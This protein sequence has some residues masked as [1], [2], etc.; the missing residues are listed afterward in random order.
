MI[1]DISKRPKLEIPECNE[2]MFL[3]NTIEY[4]V[5]TQV[6]MTWQTMEYTARWKLQDI[7][8]VRETCNNEMRT[9]MIGTPQPV[10]KS[11]RKTNYLADDGCSWN[12]LRYE[13]KPSANTD[14]KDRWTSVQFRCYHDGQWNESN[15]SFKVHGKGNGEVESRYDAKVIASTNDDCP[16]PVSENKVTTTLACRVLRDISEYC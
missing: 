8:A 9:Y 13:C 10:T 6:Q 11:D 7:C 14:F 16:Q 4:V 1:W 3:T 5:L 15:L 2:R 12:Y